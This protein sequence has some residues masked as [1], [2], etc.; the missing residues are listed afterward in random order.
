MIVT[1]KAKKLPSGNWRVQVGYTDE[2]G[3]YC[4]ASFTAETK[5]EAEFK[6]AEFLVEQKRSLKPENITLRDLASHYVD[7]LTNVR[8][9]ST[10]AGYRKIINNSL[11]PNILDA[12]IGFITPEMYQKAI[13]EFSKNHKPQTVINVNNVFSNALA[14]KGIKIAEEIALPKHEKKEISIPSEDEIK[15]LLA[16]CE[17]MRIELLIKFAVFLGLRK[18]EILALQWKDIDINSKTLTINKALVKDENKEFVVKQPKSISG[19]RKLTMPDILVNSLKPTDNP[20]DRVINDSPAA[21]ESMYKR[22]LKKL[23]MPYTFHALRHF[24]ASVML[25]ENIPNR[26][27]KERMGHSTEDMLQKV[28]QHTFPEKHEEFD[29]KMN[30]YFDTFNSNIKDDNTF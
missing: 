8:S 30:D 17:G 22:V 20:D 27:A 12:R 21:L 25:K 15:K 13:N 29:T 19:Y 24:N 10:I 18:S 1:A 26:Y 5:K 9:P 7:S 3:K 2:F 16:T 14:W 23:N 4:R 11:D 28:Y 6:A